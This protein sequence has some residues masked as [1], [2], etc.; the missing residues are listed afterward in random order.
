MPQFFLHFF[1]RRHR[2]RDLS[3]EQFPVASAQA[4]NGH[5]HRRFSHV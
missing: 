4:V 5:F 1:W 3:F 2:L